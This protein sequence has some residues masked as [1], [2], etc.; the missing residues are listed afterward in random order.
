MPFLVMISIP[1]YI[2][3]AIMRSSPFCVLHSR[4]AAHSRQPM[5]IIR[6][7]S[8]NRAKNSLGGGCAASPLC[9]MCVPCKIL[10]AVSRALPVRGGMAYGKVAKQKPKKAMIHDSMTFAQPAGSQPCVYRFMSVR[11][12][13]AWLTPMHRKIF[14]N[15]GTV[16]YEILSALRDIYWTLA[17]YLPACIACGTTHTQHP[18]FHQDIKQNTRF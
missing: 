8:S 7:A 14:A 11:L 10:S 9:L 15:I 17:K 3:L 18:A 2:S 6:S 1:Y 16:L 13:F 5:R 12:L 4:L